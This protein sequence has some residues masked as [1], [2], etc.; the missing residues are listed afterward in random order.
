MDNDHHSDEHP[1]VKRPTE[2]RQGQVSKGAPIRK[3]LVISV[4][5]TVIAFL[6]IYFAFA[7]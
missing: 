1:A 4:S 7:Q 2:A 6:I 3:V 5:L